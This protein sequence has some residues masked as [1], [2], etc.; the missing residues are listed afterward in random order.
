M[1]LKRRNVCSSIAH[2]VDYRGYKGICKM[3]RWSYL[4]GLTRREALENSL[5]KAAWEKQV[6]FSR[7]I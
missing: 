2:F 6:Y 4:E 7:M 5:I 1:V 3:N